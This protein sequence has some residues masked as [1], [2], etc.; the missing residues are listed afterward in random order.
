VSRCA[1]EGFLKPHPDMLV[2]LMEQA[3]VEPE[4]TLMIGDTT[5]TSS[6]RETPV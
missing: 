1:D 5:P 2:T 6:S 4:E 3:G